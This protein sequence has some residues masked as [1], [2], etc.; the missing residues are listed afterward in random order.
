MHY[1]RIEEAEFISRPNR[2]IANI[3]IHGNVQQ[4][5]VKN[6][7]R[8]KELLIPGVK[9]YVESHTD[10]KRK[11]KYSLIA[12]IKGSLLINMDSQAPN[13]V[14]KEWLLEKQPF[15]PLTLLKPETTYGESRFDFYMETE[16]KKLFM[17]VKGVT[18]EENGVVRFPD[19]PTERGIKHI[20][21]LIQAK[22]EG[23]EACLMF[24]VQMKG[25]RY[26]EPNE[27]AQKAFG[28]ALRKAKQAGVQIFAYDCVVKPDGLWIDNEVEVRV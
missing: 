22:E 1:E 2:F 3:L 9:I 23:Y 11:T 16:E 12:V 14:V 10:P 21:E 15:G 28:A 8:C 7:G 6:T 4:C 20:M 24:V 5:H 25:V 26:F 27:V 13:K 19:A 17:E 18:L